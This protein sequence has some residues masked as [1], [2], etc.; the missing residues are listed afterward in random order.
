MSDPDRDVHQDA[1]LTPTPRWVKVF[2]W[3]GGLA[4]L[5]ALAAL[6]SGRPHGPGRHFTP[7]STS[8]TP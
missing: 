1:P 7:S 2:A 8:S 5:L 6:L 4:L 3:G